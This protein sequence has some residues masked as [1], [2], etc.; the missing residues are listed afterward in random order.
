MT[1]FTKAALAVAA[2]LIP[3]A[4]SAAADRC[5]VP[6]YGGSVVGYKA[7]TNSFGDVVPAAHILASICKAKYEGLDRTAL[8]NAGFTDADINTM[9]V[10]DLAVSLLEYMR[11]VLRRDDNGNN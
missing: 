3:V 4:A 10:P 1:M 6:P 11:K 7:Y 8:Y 5:S 9:D 2:M